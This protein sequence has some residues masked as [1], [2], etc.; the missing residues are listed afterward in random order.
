MKA[1][2]EKELLCVFDCNKV[3]GFCETVE[4]VERKTEG[5]ASVEFTS[6]DKNLIHVVNPDANVFKYLKSQKG[7]DGIII[8]YI[9]SAF[10]IHLIEC[11]RTLKSKSYSKMKQQ[12]QNSYYTALAVLGVLSEL[13]IPINYSPKCYACYEYEDSISNRLKLST[14]NTKDNSLCCDINGESISIIRVKLKDG[15]GTYSIQ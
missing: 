9:N 7:C 1:K 15:K 3:I 5:K 10:E 4:V 6:F 13:N 14:P 12:L 11:K 8:R 2:I